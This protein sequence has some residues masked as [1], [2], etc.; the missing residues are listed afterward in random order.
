MSEEA[1][2]GLLDA[3]RGRLAVVADREFYQR[4][5][6]G[7]LNALMAASEKVENAADLLPEPVD[8]HLRHYLQRQSFTK[9]VAWLEERQAGL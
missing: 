1:Y 5:P 4:D 8:P 2:Q 9:A 7:H 6:G 3:L